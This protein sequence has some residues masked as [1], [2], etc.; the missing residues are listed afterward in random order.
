MHT[1]DKWYLLYTRDKMGEEDIDWHTWWFR[2]VVRLWVYQRSVEIYIYIYIYK[3]PR[4]CDD[5]RALYYDVTNPA[6]MMS[7]TPLL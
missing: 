5:I 3:I 4:Q 7:R 1:T 2:S 6:T